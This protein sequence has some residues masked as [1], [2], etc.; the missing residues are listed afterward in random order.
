MLAL[1]TAEMESDDE[2]SD[3]N[4]EKRGGDQKNIFQRS[5]EFRKDCRDFEGLFHNDV[6][7]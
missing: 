5:T 4:D 2:A 1:F 3:Q 7:S 6:K